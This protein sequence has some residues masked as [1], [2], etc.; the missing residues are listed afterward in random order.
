M[1]Q[2][3]DGLARDQRESIISSTLKKR[4]QES[5]LDLVRI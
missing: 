5:M 2:S 4:I 1:V 3:Y